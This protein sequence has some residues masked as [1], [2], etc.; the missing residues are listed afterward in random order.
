LCAPTS[1]SRC[2]GPRGTSGGS[3]LAPLGARHF[4]C[5]G[6]PHKLLTLV[7]Q[8]PQ[9]RPTRSASAS[10]RWPRSC[11]AARQRAASSVSGPGSDA[12]SRVRA[13]PPLVGAG[14]C[15]LLR[16]RLKRSNKLPSPLAPAGAVTAHLMGLHSAIKMLQQQLL[17]LQQLVARVNSGGRQPPT[18][19][20]GGLGSVSYVW[21]RAVG[22][23]FS[24]ATTIVPPPPPQARWGT[25]TR[26]RG[27]ST[28]SST[29]YPRSPARASRGTSCWCGP[30]C[31]RGCEDA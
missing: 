17:T 27:R 24:L 15:C 16:H 31:A 28:P 26:W 29:L 7:P 20:P 3:R 14:V 11:Q 4:L 23:V 12:C 19:L 25:H 13:Q 9:R 30:P 8:T 21:S 5:A 6:S 10:T 22:V 18:S 1:R 2:A